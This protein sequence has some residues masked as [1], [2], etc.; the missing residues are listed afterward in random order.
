[1]QWSIILRIHSLYTYN[2]QYYY[3]ERVCYST[4]CYLFALSDRADVAEGLE[5]PWVGKPIIQKII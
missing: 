3:E 5:C 2:L 4:E 1:M